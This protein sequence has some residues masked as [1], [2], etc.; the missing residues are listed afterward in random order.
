MSGPIDA[1][2]AWRPIIALEDLCEGALHVAEFAGRHI[3]IYHVEGSFYVTS[4]ISGACFALAPED[5]LEA[6]IVPGPA[7]VSRI[8]A[9]ARDRL[10]GPA[11]VPLER[12]SVRL[13]DGVVEV[14][15]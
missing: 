11:G 8:E 10:A 14:R 13:A 12:C 4:N 2:A 6:R 9:R 5:L 15:V 7:H 1:A 3:A